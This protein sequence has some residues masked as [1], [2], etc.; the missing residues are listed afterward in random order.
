[1]IGEAVIIIGIPIVRSAA[2][3]LQH[4]LKDGRIERFEVKELLTTV[5]SMSVTGAILYFG[6][7][8]LGIDGAA[9]G[10]TAGA[11]IIDKLM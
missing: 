2:G 11:W 10:A 5:L 1:M 3:W 9:F 6:L 4:S 7:S 8:S